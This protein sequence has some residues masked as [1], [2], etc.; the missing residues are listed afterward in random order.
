MS[1]AAV[2]SPVRVEPRALI[3]LKLLWLFFRGYR[4]PWCGSRR[5]ET[6][7]LDLVYADIWEDACETYHECTDCRAG[8][9]RGE[10]GSREFGAPPWSAQQLGYLTVV[11]RQ[12]KK[13]DVC[14]CG[15]RIP[16]PDNSLL[17]YAAAVRQCLRCGLEYSQAEGRLVAHKPIC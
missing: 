6:K 11:A 7:D 15:G 4:C 8:F 14:V 2:A 16:K 5:I 9:H 3:V 13:G 17:A 10:R 1:M 12:D